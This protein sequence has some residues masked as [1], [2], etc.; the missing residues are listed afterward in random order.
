MDWGGGWK[1]FGEGFVIR[2]VLGLGDSAGDG[3]EGGVRRGR[4]GGGTQR[5]G[6]PSK[7]N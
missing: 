5:H 1:G 6:W 4:G 7:D 2:V 3:E